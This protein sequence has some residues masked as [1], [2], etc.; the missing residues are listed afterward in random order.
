MRQWLIIDLEATTEEGGWP[1][2]EMEII[3]IGASLV[4]PDGHE[5]EHFRRFVRP[6]RRPR[7][8]AFCRELTHISQSQ[9]DGAAPLGQVW[10]QF[11]RWL[12]PHLP[13]LV[14][15]GSWPSPT[16]TSSRISPGAA[17]WPA[18]SAC[19]ARCS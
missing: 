7:L 9:I 1:V 17:S 14:G 18:P 12:E 13:H 16:T 11:E 3:E 6:L 19:T 2:E 4:A 15:W 5:L 8:T 10:P